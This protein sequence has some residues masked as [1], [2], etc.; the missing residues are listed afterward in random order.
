[1]TTSRPVT[2]NI[3]YYITNIL[4]GEKKS[5]GN[6]VY[7]LILLWDLYITNNTFENLYKKKMA[8]KRDIFHWYASLIRIDK[9]VV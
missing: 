2:D 1:M 4:G 7:I 3:A 5:I 8:L 6:S 9:I